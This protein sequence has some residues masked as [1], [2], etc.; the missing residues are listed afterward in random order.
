MTDDPTRLF[1]RVLHKI[2]QYNATYNYRV[3][4]SRARRKPDAFSLSCC[5]NGLTVRQKSLSPASRSCQTRDMCNHGCSGC[6]GRRRPVFPPMSLKK[7][8][9]RQ[10]PYPY[11]PLVYRC[12]HEVILALGVWSTS[13]PRLFCVRTSPPRKSCYPCLPFCHANE[14][15]NRVSLAASVPCAPR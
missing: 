7:K 6:L 3:I 10:R 2:I 11:P 13:R 5:S 9:T 14:C 1:A 15:N 4:S 12:T 8:P